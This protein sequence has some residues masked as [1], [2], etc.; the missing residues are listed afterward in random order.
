MSTGL[1]DEKILSGDN[2]LHWEGS[3][4][5]QWPSPSGDLVPS[6]SQDWRKS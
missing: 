1:Q 2:I 4:L 6:Q 3:K 5:L